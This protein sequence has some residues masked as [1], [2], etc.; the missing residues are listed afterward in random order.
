[1]RAKF[2]Y[3]GKKVPSV[4][5]A[6]ENNCLAFAPFEPLIAMTPSKS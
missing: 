5:I 1:M 4:S 3:A 2:T 6:F